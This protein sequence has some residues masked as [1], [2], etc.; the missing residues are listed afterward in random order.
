MAQL[1]KELPTLADHN[2]YHFGQIVS[3][4]RQLGAWPPPSG[5]QTW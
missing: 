4:R 1:L 3:L 2:T 5:G